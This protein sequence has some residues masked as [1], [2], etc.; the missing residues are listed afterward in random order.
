[1]NGLLEAASLGK[2]LGKRLGGIL[3][4]ETRPL[5]STD[6][7]GDPRSGI[8]D[9]RS[10][11]VTDGSLVKVLV[12]YDNEWGYANRLAELASRV[13]AVLA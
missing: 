9:A 11:C 5:V 2:R 8:V 4:Y 7:A 12:W 1:M 3:G 6:Y 10:T 13:A